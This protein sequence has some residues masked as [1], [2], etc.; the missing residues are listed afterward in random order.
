MDD[1]CVRLSSFA[2]GQGF[3]NVQAA[4]GAAAQPH[5]SLNRLRAFHE[6]HVFDQQTDHTLPLQ[7]RRL[8]IMPDAWEVTGQREDF[9]PRFLIESLS[10]G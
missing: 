7:V 3:E 4:G 5:L 8:L 10:V 9:L 1:V 2:G 6:R